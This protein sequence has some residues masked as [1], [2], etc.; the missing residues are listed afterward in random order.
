MTEVEG[1]AR[2]HLPLILEVERLA[3]LMVARR[4]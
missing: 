1:Q 4:C 2:A 3:R